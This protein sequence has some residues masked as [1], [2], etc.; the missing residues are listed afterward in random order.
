MVI[1]IAGLLVGLLGGASLA[2]AVSRWY[3]TSERPEGAAP[4][5]K[6]SSILDARGIGLDHTNPWRPL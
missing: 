2:Y 1:F 4:P 3:L 6:P 5:T